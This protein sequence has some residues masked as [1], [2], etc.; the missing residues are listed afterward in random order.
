MENKKKRKYQYFLLEKKKKKKCL[1]LY[2]MVGCLVQLSAEN[3]LIIAIPHEKVLLFFCVCF[4]GHCFFVSF[5]FFLTYM[6]LDN[7]GADKHVLLS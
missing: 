7:K 5:F 4:F 3:F 1:I 2:L 6:Y